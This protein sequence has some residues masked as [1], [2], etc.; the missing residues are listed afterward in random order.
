VAE[1]AARKGDDPPGDLVHVPFYDLQGT[2]G[3]SRLWFSVD[4][5]SGRVLPE[6]L[7]P[8]S[9]RVPGHA[10][11]LTAAIVGFLLMF[12][13]SAFIPHGGLAAVAVAGTS[14]FVYWVMM[15]ERGVPQ[16]D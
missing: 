1:A 5:C 2:L 11:I 6:R 4:A 12:L 7:P 14:G 16:L 10:A 13:E 15:G 3:G 8:L 9:R